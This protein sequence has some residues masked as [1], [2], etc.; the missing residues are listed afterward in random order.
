M[1]KPFA[2]VGRVALTMYAAQFVVIW[3]LEISGAKYDIGAI[4][5]GDLFVAFVATV[6]GWLIARL[7]A[8]PLE[9]VMRRFDRAFSTLGPVTGPTTLR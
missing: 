1:L 6:T 7:P 5:F 3:A 2:G 9:T 4:P 8:G